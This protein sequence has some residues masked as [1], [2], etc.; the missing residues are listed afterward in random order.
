MSR[1]S[2]D[3]TGPYVLRNPETADQE[4]PTP[5]DLNV[6]IGIRHVVLLE[7]VVSLDMCTRAVDPLGILGVTPLHAK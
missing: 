2:H 1:A 6:G 4:K 5:S 7:D 3:G